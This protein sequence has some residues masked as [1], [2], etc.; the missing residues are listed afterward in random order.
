M[1]EST[2]FR[3]SPQREKIL[4]YVK[5]TKNHPTAD[6]VYE[7]MREEFPSISLGTV[8][9]NLQTL[10]ANGIIHKLTTDSGADRFDGDL[11]SHTHFHCNECGKLFDIESKKPPEFP[12]TDHNI[13]S[14]FITYRGICIDCIDKERNQ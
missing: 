10:S 11:K 14:Q 8:Y 7:K 3:Y 13:L 2:I 4:E 1:K 6:M 5:N 12:K 9:R